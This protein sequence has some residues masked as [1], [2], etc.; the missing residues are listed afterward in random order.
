MCG[1]VGYVGTDHA[2]EKIIDLSLIHIWSFGNIAAH[3]GF[4]RQQKTFAFMICAA[5]HI[6]NHG[7]PACGIAMRIC[8]GVSASYAKR[9]KTT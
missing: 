1:I 5:L 4:R 3:S 7:I 9:Q 2:K 6:I 8:R